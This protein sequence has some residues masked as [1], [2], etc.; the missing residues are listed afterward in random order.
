MFE[1][2][3]AFVRMSLVAAAGV[4]CLAAVACGSSSTSGAGAGASAAA[5]ATSTADPLA[6]L[7]VA[8]VESKVVA[9]AKAS[10]TLTMKGSIVESGQTV[11]V[12]LGI[13]P[14]QG[15]TGT[16]GEGAKGSFKMIV[17]G[18]T[19][20]MNPDDAFWKANAGAEANAAIA[21]VNGRYLKVSST[22]SNE[23]SLGQLCDVSQIFS[24]DGKQDKVTKGAVTTLGGNRVLQL[25]DSDGSVAYV[26]DTAKPQLVEIAAPKGDKN[27]SGSV[28][29]TTG[30][31][32]TLTPPPA[33]QVIDGS[34]LGM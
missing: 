25:K 18:K 5:S 3:G 26:T 34:K 14:G 10:S 30:A 28:T 24:T 31:P 21:L 7:T 23:G 27:G 19:I 33:S 6:D 29:V 13:K 2:R 20:Y 32:V 16:I 8:Q 22:D 4:S 1:E 15:C 11:S 9:D 12:D 17:I